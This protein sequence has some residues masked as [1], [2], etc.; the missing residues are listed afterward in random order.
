VFLALAI[1]ALVEQRHADGQRRRADGLLR[2]QQDSNRALQARIA[3]DLRK[4]RSSRAADEAAARSVVALR[5][6]NKALTDQTAQL[7]RT[8]DALAEQNEALRTTNQ[9]L[10]GE[11]DSL[12]AQNA[13][14][15]RQINDL[16]AEY[17]DLR[18][19]AHE[20]STDEASLKE[21]GVTLNTEIRALDAQHSAVRKANGELWTKLRLL[22]PVELP[23][24]TSGGPPPLAPP[25]PAHPEIAARFRIP[26]DVGGS[27][28]LRR[29]VESLEATLQALLEQRARQADEAG[30]LRRANGL[31]ARQRTALRAET[32]QLGST[33]SGLVRRHQ[34]LEDTRARAEAENRRLKPQAASGSA[35]NA[36]AR[37]ANGKLQSANA[38]RQA[39]NNERISRV[40]DLQSAIGD[41]KLQNASLVEWITP[42][43]DRLVRGARV[44]R[45]P[46]IAAL[47]AVDAYRVA[48]YDPDD[49]AHPAVYD[50]LWTALGRLDP[51]AP[52]QLTAGPRSAAV[53]SKLCALTRGPVTAAEQAQLRRY[54]PRTAQPALLKPCG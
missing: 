37:A 25:A 1:L 19:Q 5:A 38:Q 15:A 17:L 53:K 2:V 24:F 54:L 44:E 28:S 16:N 9:E 14:L 41:T 49:P 48:P 52:Q 50:A 6:T 51:T 36:K 47:L 12:N 29:K 46:R 40:A 8:R 43:V 31:L 30:W 34:A 11:I 22:G 23:A 45:D 13:A 10:V 42:H 7:T 20:L 4:A 33:R 26:G 32:A 35:R 21:N 27:D 39:T 3:T 18:R